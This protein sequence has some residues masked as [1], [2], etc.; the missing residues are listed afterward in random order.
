VRPP[1]RHRRASMP[2][3]RTIR[4]LC[5]KGTDPAVRPPVRPPAGHECRQIAPLGRDRATGNF[6]PRFQDL[7]STRDSPR[8]CRTRRGLGSAPDSISRYVC[9]V[10]RA[11]LKRETVLRERRIADAIIRRQSAEAEPEQCPARPQGFGELVAALRRRELDS[12]AY[13]S[14]AGTMKHRV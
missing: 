5:L 6:I 8:H 2:A 10:T 3:D 14:F 11:Q 13:Q 9:A 7:F 12:A 1:V 4:D